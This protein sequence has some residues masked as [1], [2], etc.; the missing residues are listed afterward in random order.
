M[1]H[2]LLIDRST[3]W[4]RDKVFPLW[5]RNGV[6]LSTGVFV[7]NLDFEGRPM[8]SILRALVQA[9]QIYSFAE[10]VRMGI[11][12]RDVGQHLIHLSALSFIKNYQADTGGIIHGVYADGRVANSDCELYTQAFG[13]FAMAQAFE[14]SR[15][16]EFKEAAVKILSYLDNYR[17]H[18]E[19]GY[20]E[21]KSGKT[22]YQSNPHMH[23]FEGFLAWRSIDQDPDWKERCD[24][25]A[26]LCRKSFIQKGTDLLAEHFDP[27]WKPQLQNVKFI[28]EPGHH[29]EWSWLFCQYDP[30]LRSHPQSVARRLYEKAN[31]F[32]L[33]KDGKLVVDE[34]WSSGE[35]CKKSSRFWP[36]SERVK[37]AVIL[38]DGTGADQAL[39]S[40]LLFFLDEERGLW[41]D[42]RLEDGTYAD[43]PVKASSLYHIINAISEYS[44][45]RPQIGD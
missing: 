21:L 36:Q 24:E 31:Q 35:V 4:L 9:R 42:T 19:G 17:K 25:I 27:D 41:K 6:D 3:N 18:P 26:F 29:Y 14:F 8:K 44:K 7:E 5:L 16:R 32:G 40:L 2:R 11:L 23:L 10:G 20:T 28:F 39:E 12:D 33:S 37:A 13:I 43:I 45:Y 30:M 38:G 22:F 1:N 34:V 15:A